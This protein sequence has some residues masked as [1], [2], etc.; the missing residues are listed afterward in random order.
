M[1]ICIGAIAYHLN[2]HYAK[3]DAN[4]AKK[5]LS[6]FILKWARIKSP[7]VNTPYYI[8]RLTIFHRDGTKWQKRK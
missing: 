5:E 3:P 1:D 6:D 4:P 2:S 8:P 7:F